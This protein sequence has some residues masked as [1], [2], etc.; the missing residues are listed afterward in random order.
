MMIVKLYSEKRLVS[1]CLLDTQASFLL[2]IVVLMI[3][4]TFLY[5]YFEVSFQD[6]DLDS[7]FR[8]SKYEALG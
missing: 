5:S 6:Y 8:I 2:L 1:F 4:A 3:S 7:L